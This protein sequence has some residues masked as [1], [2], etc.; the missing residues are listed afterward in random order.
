MNQRSITV[1]YTNGRMLTRHVVMLAG[2]G[3]VFAEHTTV[4]IIYIFIEHVLKHGIWLV[5][6]HT[7]AYG[8]IITERLV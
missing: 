6:V 5:V 4:Q 7:I 1:C 8:K 2:E 3:V